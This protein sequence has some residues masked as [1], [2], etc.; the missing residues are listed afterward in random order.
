M[1]AVANRPLSGEIIEPGDAVTVYA[2][3][4]PF[5]VEQ[6]VSAVPAGMS[7]AEIAR[8]VLATNG[9]KQLFGTLQAR[10]NGDVVDP[11]WWERIRL[12][13]GTELR[14]Q[15]VPGKGAGN[16]L[17]TILLIAV[18]VVAL[19]VSGGTLL[20][21]VTAA[22]GAAI[23]VSSGVAGSILAAAIALGGRFNRNAQ[24]FSGGSR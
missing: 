9:E 11:D 2:R 23:G 5:K 22:F 8:L 12:K 17:R 10:V 24:L 14:L 21:G 16:L 6:K 19:A 1:N 15:A 20:P 13:P 7:V 3:L 18:S 4:H